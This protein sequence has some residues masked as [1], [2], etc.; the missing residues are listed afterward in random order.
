MNMNEIS[1]NELQELHKYSY[2]IYK[3][4]HNALKF[5]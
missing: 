2:E 4:N 3:Y 5:A 1:M